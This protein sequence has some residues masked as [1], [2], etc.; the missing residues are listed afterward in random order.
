ML[1]TITTPL[2]APVQTH[3]HVQLFWVKCTILLMWQYSWSVDW[4][5]RTFHTFHGKRCNC[6]TGLILH[7]TLKLQPY[8][9]KKLQVWNS[10]E[11][12][13]LLIIMQKLILLAVIHYSTVTTKQHFTTKFELKF[14]FS[15]V[16]AVNL[17]G[18]FLPLMQLRTLRILLHHHD[19][20]TLASML[21]LSFYEIYM[22]RL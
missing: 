20:Y 6:I 10:K 5:D 8:T 11:L 9:S 1:P 13:E 3:A 2:L 14:N 7:V 21:C 4:Y 17:C 16:S 19:P 22:I 15:W 12:K 18:A